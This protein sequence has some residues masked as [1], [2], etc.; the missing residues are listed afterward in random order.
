MIIQTTDFLKTITVAQI[1]AHVVLGIQVESL[2]IGAPGNEMY[3]ALTADQALELA[4]GLTRGA[5]EIQGVRNE[6]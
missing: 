3:A 1:Q 4:L 2:V 6:A 5:K